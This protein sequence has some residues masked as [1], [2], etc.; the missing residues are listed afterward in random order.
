[1][2][3]LL[4]VII[5]IGCNNIEEKEGDNGL[6]IDY[7]NGYNQASLS[8]ADLSPCTPGQ[9]I[10]IYY[11]SIILGDNDTYQSIHVHATDNLQCS[12]KLSNFVAQIEEDIFNSVRIYIL[13]FN[14]EEHTGELFPVEQELITLRCKL[15][16][17]SNCWQIE[18]TEIIN[19]GGLSED[20]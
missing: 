16:R 20:E 14:I 5:S 9:I 8:L 15:I 2:L 11:Q 13:S 19:L 17:I 18:W 7:L 6:V 4:L 1:M 3:I 10:Q 12:Y